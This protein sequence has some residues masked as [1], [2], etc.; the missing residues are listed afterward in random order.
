MPGSPVSFFPSP[1]PSAAGSRYKP[2]VFRQRR[3]CD[4]FSKLCL[5]AAFPALPSF[6]VLHEAITADASIAFRATCKPSF[7]YNHLAGLGTNGHLTSTFWVN[8]S[9]VPCVPASN[10]CRVLLSVG[11]WIPPRPGGRVTWSPMEEGLISNGTLTVNLMGMDLLKPVCLLILASKS[12][13]G[14]GLIQTM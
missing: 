9:P 6:S 1:F 10:R 11:Y 14:L 7:M 5:W 12:K 2:S 3:Q 8:S 13:Y 4:V